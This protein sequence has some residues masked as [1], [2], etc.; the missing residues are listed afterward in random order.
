MIS[1]SSPRTSPTRPS[2][3]A[4]A[5]KRLVLP[6]RD[7]PVRR[8]LVMG[9]AMP[10]LDGM[11][12]DW[13]LTVDRIIDHAARMFPDIEVV[14]RRHSGAIVRTGYAA[15]AEEAR[16]LLRALASQGIGAGRS[17]EHTSELQSL[18][19]NSYAVCCLKKKK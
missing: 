18:M 5:Q 3:R 14:T 2:C 12:Q 6:H 11:M 9:A 17:E 13:P 4:P 16:L 15:L 7:P 19:R 8:G 1:S 10:A